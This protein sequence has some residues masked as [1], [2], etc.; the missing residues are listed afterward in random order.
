MC[1]VRSPVFTD[2]TALDVQCVSDFF[3]RVTTCTHL[4][5]DFSD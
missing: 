5:A 4:D 3:H 1:A 2:C